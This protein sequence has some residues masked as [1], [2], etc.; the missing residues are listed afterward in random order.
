MSPPT[1][2]KGQELN[3]LKRKYINNK[4]VENLNTNR[5]SSKNEMNQLLEASNFMIPQNDLINDIKETIKSP[6]E[7]KKQRSQFYLNKI[8]NKLIDSASDLIIDSRESLAGLSE[9]KSI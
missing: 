6:K 5:S 7:S 3:S 4:T 9:R 8:S 1:S 2:R